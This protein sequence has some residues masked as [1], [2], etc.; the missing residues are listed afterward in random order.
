MCKN[1]PRPDTA[2]PHR[3]RPAAFS[4]RLN[5][6]LTK[7]LLINFSGALPQG[8]CRQ[9]LPRIYGR[10]GCVPATNDFRGK[11]Q[12]M[13]AASYWARSNPETGRDRPAR[14][15][16]GTTDSSPSVSFALHSD[17]QFLDEQAGT[18]P[19][20]NDRPLSRGRLQFDPRVVQRH[21]DFPAP[22]TIRRLEAMTVRTAKKLFP[23]QHT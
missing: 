11:R 14:H 1:Q 18:L 15:P 8:A 5:D 7:H 12:W 16:P 19:S 6:S 23:R 9:R 13:C 20:R 10:P 2:N 17:A 21:H 3:A 22:R 4:S